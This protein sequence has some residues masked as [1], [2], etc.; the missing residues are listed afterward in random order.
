MLLG[1]L[2]ITGNIL[3][4]ECIKPI[5]T[6]PDDLPHNKGQARN[7]FRK[8]MPVI[9][10]ENLTKRYGNLEVLHG[11]ELEMQDAEFTVLVGPSGCGKSTLIESKWPQVQALMLLN[12]ISRTNTTR[13]I[14]KRCYNNASCP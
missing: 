8:Y 10:L 9:R 7:R 1:L 14:S 13:T 2:I 11:I 3:P 5:D 4:A 6:H 12:V